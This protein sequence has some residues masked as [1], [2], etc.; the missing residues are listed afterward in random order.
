MP[1]LALPGLGLEPR[2]QLLQIFGRQ[3]VLDADYRA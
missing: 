2:N 3:A 1:T